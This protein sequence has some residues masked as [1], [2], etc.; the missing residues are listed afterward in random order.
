ML[1]VRRIMSNGDFMFYVT[2][3]VGGACRIQASEDL[4]NWED[5]FTFSN[6]QAVTPYADP[7]ADANPQRFYRVVSP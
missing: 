2:N 1:G 6:R 7:G 4:R 5:I 3:Q